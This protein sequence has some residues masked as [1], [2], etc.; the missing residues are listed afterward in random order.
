MA[1]SGKGHY[2]W[3]GR[4][5]INMVSKIGVGPI[6]PGLYKMG[7]SY[8]NPHLGPCTINLDPIAHTITF[9]RSL[10]RI[11]GNNLS[12]DASHG[13][14]VVPIRGFREEIA[15]QIELGFDVIEVIP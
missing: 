10:F 1:Y 9:G 11:H 2:K 14:I 8:D 7:K 5:N 12:N 6:P 3:Q 15:R 4:N 13:C